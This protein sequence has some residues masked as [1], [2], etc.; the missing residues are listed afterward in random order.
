MS[1]IRATVGV[2][3]MLT[4]NEAHQLAQRKYYHSTKGKATEAKFRKTEQYR[5][6]KRLTD[7]RHYAKN[8]DRQIEHSRVSKLRQYGLTKDAYDKQVALQNNCCACCGEPET[9]INP[10]TKQ[11][12]RLSVDHCHATGKNRGLV[13]ARCNR[14]V[15]PAVEHWSEIIPKAVS[16]LR[17]Q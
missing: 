12:Q 6:G 15:I 8:K 2:N 16:Y 14:F 9:H 1:E 11:V 5:Q 3:F 7:S 17:R 13:C 10:Y 4:K